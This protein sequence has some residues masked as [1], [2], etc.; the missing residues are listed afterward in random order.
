MGLGPLLSIP[1]H[2][3]DNVFNGSG[4]EIYFPLTLTLSPIGGE[5][6]IKEPQ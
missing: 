6:K 2:K 4:K 5:G 3:F 1:F